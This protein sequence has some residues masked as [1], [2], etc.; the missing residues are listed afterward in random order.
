MGGD[1]NAFYYMPAYT[2]GPEPIKDLGI[3]AQVNW[4]SAWPTGAGD[5]ETSRDQYYMSVLGSGRYVGT[6]SPGFFAHFGYKNFIW[7]GDNW[8]YSMRWEQLISMRQQ[9]D[10]VE[11]VAWNDVSGMLHSHA[12]LDRN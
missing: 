1:R 9:I 2:T 11:I 3:D 10:Q 5:I 6:V 12:G 8:L 4:G 7:R